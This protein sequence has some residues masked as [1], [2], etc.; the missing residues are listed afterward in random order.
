MQRALVI[1]LLLALLFVSGCS[2][3]SS[4]HALAVL[5]EEHGTI[6][7]DTASTVGQWTAAKVKAEFFVGDGVRSGKT[8]R[9]VLEL[10][11]DSRLA[12]EE[13][14]IVRFLERPSGSGTERIDLQM[15][16][17]TLEVGK[18]P[19]SLETDVGLAV[20][21]PGTRLSL[22]KD[23]K[24]IRYEVSVG[25]ARFEDKNGEKT[26]VGPGQGVIVATSAARVERIE[27]KP[28][29]AP[30]PSA[31][32]SP[33]AE[34]SPPQVVTG[35]VAAKVTG[36]GASVR[37]PGAATFAP[38]APGESTIAAGSTLKLAGG[39]TMDV[40]RG[41]E[42]ATLRGAGEFVVAESGRS[43]IQTRGGGIAFASV[44]QD[45]QVAV[46][47]GTIVVKTGSSADVRVDA[48]AAKVAVATGTAEL[49]G[50]TGTEQLS[51]GEEGTLGAQ[52][53]AAVAGRG[54][55]YVDFVAA[56]GS[57][58]VHDPKP[59]TAIGFSTGSTCPEGA[60]VDV[61]GKGKLRSRGTGVVSVLVPTGAHKYQ[62]FCVTGSSVSNSAAASGTVSVLRDAGT[63][64][65]P[66]TAA[67]TLV[68]TDGRNY[69]V[70]YQNILP[71]ISVRWP[72]PPAGGP[73]TLTVASPGGKTESHSSGA[74]SWSFASGAL[75]EGTH[76][77]T[78]ATASARS[79]TTT[80]ELRFDNAAPTAT[81]TSPP[82]GFAPGSTVTVAGAALEGWTISAG[83]KE[84]PLDGQQRFSG[85]VTA[86]SG[87]RALAVQFVNPRRG[88]HYYL[89]RAA[90]H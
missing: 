63:A 11:D 53:K 73:Y 46:P 27:T 24:G 28:E 41:G 64:R 48:E 51:A 49:R 9:A 31:A 88:V 75:R 86:P 82:D 66:R 89:R 14:T 7:R 83:G 60:I 8:S 52:G 3:C 29:A 69:T 13:S 74:A 59:P 78:F 35:D 26:A 61:G 56:G 16:E 40:H 85:A 44:S 19:L 45:I 37:S 25:L 87:E 72:N 36:G 55:G 22:R 79:K 32:P 81:L 15:G 57:F 70:L 47:G 20:I 84:L 1:A 90:G 65:I 67:T 50:P 12:L 38:V 80:L 33:A 77:L 58:A 6:E 10:S 5:A 43:F 54:P 39:T 71:R 76:R 17:A 4:A 30:S 21:D 18:E 34:V 68:D 2:R 42:H 62:V 23:G